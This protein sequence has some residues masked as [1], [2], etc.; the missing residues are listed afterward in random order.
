MKTLILTWMTLEEDD[1]KI[2]ERHDSYPFLLF[3]TLF[4]TTYF[5]C[6]CLPQVLLLL[7]LQST[8]LQSTPPSSLSLSQRLCEMLRAGNSSDYIYKE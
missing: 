7:V 3:G 1:W 2:T 6:F 8:P 4:S 5:S